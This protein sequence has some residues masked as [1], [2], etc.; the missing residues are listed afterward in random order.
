MEADDLLCSRNAREEKGSL[1]VLLHAERAPSEGPRSTRAFEDR[2][3]HLFKRKQ[4]S[5][6][7]L[8]QPRSPAAVRPAQVHLRKRDRETGYKLGVF[9]LSPPLTQVIYLRGKRIVQPRYMHYP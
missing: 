6:E 8:L 1:A 4:A 3:A 2:P 9:S 7:E 5:L